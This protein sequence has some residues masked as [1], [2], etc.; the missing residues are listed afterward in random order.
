MQERFI[1]V[2][3]PGSG[4]ISLSVSKV[5]DGFAKVLFYGQEPSDG[6]SDGGIFNPVKASI[7]LKKLIESAEE[8]LDIVISKIIIPLPRY[9]TKLSTGELKVERSD[10]DSYITEEEVESLCDFALEK[11]LPEMGEG[12]EIYSMLPQSFSTEELFQADHNDVVGS[13]SGELSGDFKIIS[14]SA[15]VASNSTKLITV[16]GKAIG[17]RYFAPLGLGRVELSDDEM[18]NG[19]ALIEI[20]AGVTSVSIFNR[21]VMRYYASIPFGGKTITEDIRLETGFSESL[22][23][24][25]KLAYGFAMPDRLQ[26]MSDKVLQVN[27]ERSGESNQLSIKYLCE[28]INS[29]MSE[30]VK[31]MLFKIGQSGYA[32]RLRG[33]IVL[34]GGGSELAGCAALVK[35]MSGYNVRVGYIRSRD[36]DAGGCPEMDDASAA[37]HYAM[38]TL[39]LDDEFLNCVQVEEKQAET[40][41]EGEKPQPAEGDIFAPEEFGEAVKPEKHPKRQKEPR[42][43]KPLDPNSLVGKLFQGISNNFDKLGAEEK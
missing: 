34:C 13:S 31:A 10:A 11:Y 32:D 29:R 17:I 40:E 6:I 18:E 39:A 5:A 12:Q 30:I 23:E 7:P 24:N 36:I 35:E 19:A 42:R 16:C 22:C 1:V 9:K 28:I 21:G 41:S 33:G 27:D 26:S 15:K 2:A 20:G 14:G 38:I 3:D 4:K 8:S 25:I 37:S 43:S